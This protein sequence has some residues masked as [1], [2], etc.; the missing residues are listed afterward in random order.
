VLAPIFLLI[1]GYVTWLFLV[2]FLLR[3]GSKL[4]SFMEVSCWCAKEHCALNMEGT[5]VYVGA[6]H[7]GS[8][9]LARALL[10]LIGGLVA[11]WVGAN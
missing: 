11:T 10:V 7:R 2:L 8:L 1:Q 9:N 6:Q 4:R 3:G 5:S